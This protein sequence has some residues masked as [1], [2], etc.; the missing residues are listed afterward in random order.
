MPLCEPCAYKNIPYALFHQAPPYIEMW[1]SKGLDGTAPWPPFDD[2]LTRQQALLTPKPT[3]E[4]ITQAVC[5]P[6]PPR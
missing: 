5:D 4:A 1:V 2:A 3:H 6:Y